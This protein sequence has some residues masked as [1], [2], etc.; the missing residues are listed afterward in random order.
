MRTLLLLVTAVAM[1]AGAQFV[2][3]MLFGTQANPKAAFAEWMLRHGK[4]Y[5]N[6][7]K[8]R[9]RP[10]TG[11]LS[12]DHQPTLREV[13]PASQGRLT[14]HCAHYCVKCYGYHAWML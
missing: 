12:K 2:V 5:A 13:V 6:D 1:G 4:G 14:F 3:L 8:V 10:G 9:M 7:A 11:W